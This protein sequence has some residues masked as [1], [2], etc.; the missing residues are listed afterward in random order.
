MTKQL[1]W[2]MDIQIDSRYFFCWVNFTRM[3][4]VPWLPEPAPELTVENGPILLSLFWKTTFLQL[5]QKM[6][7]LPGYKVASERYL[8]LIIFSPT[9]VSIPE[10]NKEKMEGRQSRG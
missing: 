5:L 9:V 7:I 6:D 1:F 2:G 4:H 8:T 10:S 3:L